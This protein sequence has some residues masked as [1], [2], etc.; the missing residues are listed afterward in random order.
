MAA[1]SVGPFSGHAWRL[2]GSSAVATLGV[3]ASGITLGSISQRRL[4][5]GRAGETPPSI[6]CACQ[7]APGQGSINQRDATSIRTN[8]LRDFVMAS[9][10]TP[11]HW[12]RRVYSAMAFAR[13]L[14]RQS[15]RI[16]PA[17]LPAKVTAR[18]KSRA[19]RFGPAG[20]NC[21]CHAG[22][23]SRA[24][25]ICDLRP[26]KQPDRHSGSSA[27][28]MICVH[29]ID[30]ALFGLRWPRSRISEISIKLLRLEVTI[31]RKPA[32]R[33]GARTQNS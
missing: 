30:G 19:A 7:A 8:R 29:V 24:R 31:A 10:P 4:G 21:R 26:T 32:T 16:F 17:T 3:C 25:P 14:I 22:I 5:S 6:F 13:G 33:L 20:M 11:L 9:P 23:A 1:T 18:G 2:L 27:F 12:V 15:T 28:A